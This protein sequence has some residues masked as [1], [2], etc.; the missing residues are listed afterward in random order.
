MMPAHALK[1][2]TVIFGMLLTLASVAQMLVPYLPP[3][4]IG[5]AGTAVGVVVIILRF[6]TTL[7]LDQK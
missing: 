7:P 3:Q 1:S 4:Y 2:R 6:V 5:A